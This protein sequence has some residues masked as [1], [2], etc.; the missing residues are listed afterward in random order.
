M[1]RSVFC[2]VEYV[3]GNDS[4]L[5]RHKVFLYNFDAS[6]MVVVMALL[7]WIHL[8]EVEMLKKKNCADVL[9]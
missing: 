7:N 1:V 5:L 4:H 8:S 3:M 6:L 2:V 9:L